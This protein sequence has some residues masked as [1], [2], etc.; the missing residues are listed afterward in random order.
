LLSHLCQ[1]LA[2]NSA[3]TRLPSTIPRNARWS[4]A[5]TIT[6]LWPRVLNPAGKRLDNCGAG[7]S[8]LRR[9]QISLCDVQLT[10]F[11][12][13]RPAFARQTDRIGQQRWRSIFVYSSPIFRFW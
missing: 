13:D 8:R 2:G 5:R 11:R 4:A 1:S 6:C 9:C 7:E 3:R 10:R 12:G